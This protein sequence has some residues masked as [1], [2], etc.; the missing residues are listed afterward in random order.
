MD[1]SEDEGRGRSTPLAQNPG[2]DAEV[3]AQGLGE[4]QVVQT[5]LPKEA[6]SETS[7]TLHAHF[8]NDVLQG[9]LL[10]QPTGGLDSILAGE[11]TFAAGG[12]APSAE[13]PMGSN[14]AMLRAMRDFEAT[15]YDAA[16]PV[17]D[18]LRPSGG[19][20]LPFAV[21]ERFERAMGGSFSHVRVHKDGL[22]ASQASALNAHAFT[23]EAH[24]WFGAGEWAPGTYKGDRLI[25]HELTHVQQHDQ[26]RISPHGKDMEVSSPSDPL[27]REAYANENRVVGALKTIDKE[28]AAE[29]NQ[30]E[31]L[32]VDMSDL[33]TL[34]EQ[35]EEADVETELSV[36]AEEET[37]A[38][39]ADIEVSDF[40]GADPFDG[41][42]DAADAAPSDAGVPADVGSPG[43]G[44]RAMARRST[45][46]SATNSG[47]AEAAI[48]ASA[49]G[50]LPAAI[51]AK[52]SRALG[53]DFSHV[54]VHT[55]SAADQAAKSLNAQAFALGSELFFAAG[56]FSPDTDKGQQVLAHELVHVKQHD[57]GELSGG[58]DGLEV[59]N[60]DEIAER[61][62]YAV[63]AEIG[64]A[65]EQVET[66]DASLETAPLD[67]VTEMAPAA[68]DQE[69]IG[70]DKGGEVAPETGVAMLRE[71]STRQDPGEKEGDDGQ[72]KPDKVE[73]MLAGHKI[74]VS[75][76]HG[77]EALKQEVDLN[78][79][80]VPGLK[81][82][83]ATLVFTQEWAV[84]SG[85]LEGKLTIG[86]IIVDNPVTLQVT[87]SSVSGKIEDVHI[88]LPGDVLEGTMDLEVS[89]DGIGGEATFT[90]E[91]INCGPGFE[92]TSGELT[93]K[94]EPGSTEISSEGELQGK[95]A[96]KFDF[97]FTAEIDSNQL[98][99]HLDVQ[100]AN[101]VDLGNNLSITGVA[102]GGRFHKEE[103][104][105]LEGSV[106]F[107]IA[108][109]ARADLAASVTFPGGGGE[110]KEDGG[111]QTA[112]DGTVEEVSEPTV[113][114]GTAAGAD[115]PGGAA[116]PS[117]P[118][119]GG[120]RGGARG[121]DA[122][123][124]G[125]AP[126]D[127]G[128]QAGS[129]DGGGQE[130]VVEQEAENSQ[131]GGDTA[132]PLPLSFPSPGKWNFKGT[133]TQTRDGDLGGGVTATGTVVEV[134]VIDNV[135]QTVE[136][137]RSTL[138]L[139]DDWKAD[140]KGSYNVQTNKFGGE[141]TVSLE[142][143][144]DLGKGL[145]LTK[146]EATGKV[147]NNELTTISGNMEATLE[148]SGVPK[149][150][151]KLE[152]VEYNVK[153]GE[154]S[155][156]GK[157][158][159]A[160]E[161]ELAKK[162][163]YSLVVVP[164]TEI[165]GTV[166]AN[167]LTKVNGEITLMLREEGADF[168]EA[169]IDCEYPLTEGGKISGTATATL[170]QEREVGSLAGDKVFLA[171]GS[172]L[173]AKITENE[174]ESI[175]G[176]VVLSVRD[177]AEWAKATIEGEYTLAGETAGYT[178][179][180][181]LEVSGEKEVGGVG[182]YKLYVAGYESAESTAHFEQSKLT[183][184]DGKVPFAIKDG[185]EEPLFKGALSGEYIVESKQ[186]TGE[187]E[188][189][190]ARD[191]DFEVAG[192]IVRVKEGTGGSGK[193]N[194]N[195]VESVTGEVKAEILVD[196]QVEFEFSGSGT[197]DVQNAKVTEAEGT[198]TL[199]RT[200][201]PFGEGVIEVS[202]LTATA[203][204]ENNELKEVTGG[205]KIKVP[206]LND[207]E[208]SFEITWKKE[209]G[210]DSISGS[211]DVHLIIFKGEKGR[212]AEGDVAFTFDGTEKFTV[213]GDVDYQLTEQI[214]GSIGV[215]MD[216]KIDPELD[217]TL[218]LNSEL[219]PA[220]QL[221]DKT[222]DILPEQN[223]QFSAGPVPMVLK[224]GALAGFGLGL[225]ALVLTSEIG[226]SKWKPL[227]EGNQVPDFDATANL[228]WGMNFNALAAAWMSLGIGVSILSAGA[229]IKGEAK[230]EVPIS[231][232]ADVTLHGG[233]DGFWGDLG[234]SA[235]LSANLSFALKPFLYANIFSKKFEHEF[236]GWNWDMGE[237]VKM[238][239]G[240]KYEFG[241][242]QGVSDQ[243][244][245]PIDTP[246]ASQADTKH[247]SKPETGGNQ[248]T[249]P[250]TGEG[251][252]DLSG[253]GDM[254]GG[255]DQAEGSGKSEM[256]ERMEQIKKIANGISAIGYL[257][258]Q[259]G[260]L[261]TWAAAA[262]PIGL[263]IRLVWKMLTGELTWGKLVDA[264]KNAIEG[265][266]ACYEMIKPYLPDWWA[267]LKQI[268]D[269]G[270]NLFDEWWNGDTKMHQ[271]VQRGEHKYA[272]A[273]M[274]AMMADKM[275]DT[276][277]SESHKHSVLTLLESGDAG[278]I[279]G[280][281]GWGTVKGKMT[282][283]NASDRVEK[284][285]EKWALSA[286]YARYVEKESFW[287]NKYTEL[288]Y[289]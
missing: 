132:G 235:G 46:R 263:V 50:K 78:V 95:V 122:A 195:T 222:I 261:L 262:G 217:G 21:Q 48:R 180:A 167:D 105:S 75:L 10:G 184:I 176:S 154:L 65:I 228:D 276:W 255:G 71:G 182:Q 159:L 230:L 38:A 252:P 277:S 72:S 123:A 41:S 57:E 84:K 253:V 169:K 168:I 109:W 181:K 63:E 126:V 283:W 278:A 202:D 121:A 179:T 15:D 61:E 282:G 260:D 114:D 258:E 236:D 34:E 200:L 208:G 125:P 244:A 5:E 92:L 76:A 266:K 17:L 7:N 257:I 285:F 20:A 1:F 35:G 138:L 152:G 238:D 165:S 96:D 198:A 175:S 42:A 148:R 56:E 237:L 275:L 94:L 147:E 44:A 43:E 284:R 146:V 249:A 45:G 83:K 192:A 233:A 120:G 232:G 186:F 269:E 26:G 213:D 108:G 173:T 205:A 115:A 79:E 223:I 157:V 215:K 97:T 144:K 99:G 12:I 19:E 190:L 64:Q 36:E 287:G 93:L 37:A 241:D 191:V 216:E 187:G 2:V 91:Q 70:S 59:S 264:V 247:E 160:E 88:P 16:D 166:E 67:L 60:R 143:P 127:M 161:Y 149:F 155:G 110:S 245:T 73:L 211:G 150:V 25:G 280:K 137:T 265:M 27:E 28:M 90:S 201:T 51:A 128:G 171:E 153:D 31:D 288:E 54:T 124:G 239:W 267:K 218:R 29:Q 286:G 242:K 178:G 145:K 11:M 156:V 24:I 279:I 254:I 226:V 3:D 256:E 23:I 274:K 52:M 246:A 4:E 135:L 139:P 281:V 85:K 8:G 203:K 40:G 243:S 140:L 214:G 32:D 33:S 13:S 224:F 158:I 196:G 270:I 172:G 193:I 185:G 133:V 206:A 210:K 22:A 219:I 9:A 251:G 111:T 259:V 66:A 188:I 248:V 62:A 86:E 141:A 129:L 289:N 104:T 231:V 112:R 163:K 273:E 6:A 101:P 209:G 142:E 151:V 134:N 170:K 77:G 82:E 47:V 116:P 68:V 212:G 271:A 100:L 107:D 225:N 240:A 74:E 131:G 207:S 103:G 98:A 199:K 89:S 220:S 39:D 204:L 162:G 189:K 229:G 81:L 113:P 268:I 117:G 80:P 87:D 18:S 221:F 102:L 227:S 106:T 174:L 58:T 197:Y 118:A 30:D 234:I 130:Q 55:D 69:E 194:A 164:G 14:Q 119:S 136:L 49:G 53:H 272:T 183:K 250:S 177:D